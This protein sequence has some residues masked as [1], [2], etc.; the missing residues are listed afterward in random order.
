[1]AKPYILI[2]T[3]GDNTSFNALGRDI[4]A[5]LSRDYRIQVISADKID[6]SMVCDVLVVLWWKALYKGLLE[7]VTVKKSTV[8]ALFDHHSWTVVNRTREMLRLAIGKADYLVVGNEQ[9]LGEL[10]DS[11]GRLPPTWIAETG[12]DTERFAQLPYPKGDFT[13]LWVGNSRAGEND[14]KGLDLVRD[15]A[16]IADVPLKIADVLGEQGEQIPYDYMPQW[17][18][19]G[20]CLMVGSRSEGTPRPLLEAMSCGRVVCATRVGTVQRLVQHGVNG[21]IV[22]DSAEQMAA[23]LEYLRHL[24]QVVDPR[25]VKTC[26]R[27][28]AIS[29]DL[30]HKAP[31]WAAVLSTALSG[32]WWRSV[33]SHRP[34]ANAGAPAV[35][36]PIDA[37]K[38]EV[39]EL[40]G[41][42]EDVGALQQMVDALEPDAPFDRP[43]VL[44]TSMHRFM[45]RTFHLIKLMARRY[46]FVLDEGKDGEFKSCDLVWCFYPF[47]CGRRA[48]EAARR[49]QVPMLQ[50]MRGNTSSLGPSRTAEAMTVYGCADRIVTLTQSL[51][52]ELIHQSPVLKHKI[53]VIPNGAAVQHDSGGPSSLPYPKPWIVCFTNFNFEAKRRAMDEIIAAFCEVSSFRGTVLI[54]GQEGLHKLPKGH[55][56]GP[57]RYLGFVRNRFGLMRAADVFLYHSHMDGQPSAMMEAMSLGCPIVVGRSPQ[58]GAAEL[59]RD[60]VSGIVRANARQLVSEAIELCGDDERADLMGKAAIAHVAKNY[61]WPAA[62]AA[63]SRL[64]DSMLRRTS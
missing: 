26:A 36:G 13:A 12:V 9:L 16:A 53:T 60:G 24:L 30:R 29:F 28:S 1:M 22:E 37:A 11:Y 7:R 64:I 58:S 45:S 10:R 2:A 52:N 34:K 54:V 55:V 51:A 42:S 32:R 50:T 14:L 19:R 6:N 41:K 3:N 15:A 18:E 25:V 33:S 38:A 48:A 43:V 40:Q 4:Q 23:G 57:C 27:R 46:R 21:V 8:L 56:G 31:V 62:A 63:Y 39:R 20:H 35:L 47:R 5:R 44:I 61:T 17:Y 49:Y 59:V